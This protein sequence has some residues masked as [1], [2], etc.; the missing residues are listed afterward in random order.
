MILAYPIACHDSSC[1]ELMYQHHI[2]CR[3]GVDLWTDFYSCCQD[4]DGRP[5]DLWELEVSRIS[6]PN[7]SVRRSNHTGD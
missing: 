4:I 1:S 3:S 2:T 7:S 6:L 5:C